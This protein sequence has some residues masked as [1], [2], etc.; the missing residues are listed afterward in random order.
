MEL[1]NSN[2]FLS[3]LCWNLNRE[4]GPY[5]AN[6]GT[7]SGATVTTIPALAHFEFLLE[8]LIPFKTTC[9]GAVAE[10]IRRPPGHMQNENTPLPFTC[11][12]KEYSAGGSMG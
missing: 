2:I 12:T 4:S 8:L 10:G 3:T 11:V 1:E 9:P 6:S 5:F 7:S